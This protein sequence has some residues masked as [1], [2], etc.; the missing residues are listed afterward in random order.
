MVLVS[1]RESGPA[2]LATAT[3]R[4]V[5]ATRHVVATTLTTIAGFLPL[6]LDGGGFWP[7]MAICIAGGVSGATLMALVGVPAADRWLRGA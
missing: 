7:P 3:E 2:T 5:A 6:I 4:V 1:V